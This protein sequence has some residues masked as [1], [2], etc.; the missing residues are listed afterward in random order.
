MPFSSGGFYGFFWR[1]KGK[2]HG[3]LGRGEGV[4]SGFL[5][6]HVVV[7]HTLS[8]LSQGL[9][10]KTM[11]VCWFKTHFPDNINIS[12][13]VFSELVTLRQYFSCY[14]MNTTELYMVSM[15]RI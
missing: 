5:K 10:N 14:E 3:Q 11:R 4:F 12:K 6:V 2:G 8:K 15:P 9:S 13:F 1:G 7:L